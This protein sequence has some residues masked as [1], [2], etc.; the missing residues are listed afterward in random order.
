M[1]ELPDVDVYVDCLR[2]RVVGQQL[3]KVRLATPFVLRSVAPPL[4]ELHGKT[5]TEVRRLGKRIVFALDGD[6][7]L[8]I[9]L[10]I[11]GRFKWKPG[12]PSESTL[13]TRPRGRN[14]LVVFSFA[15]GELSL[16]EAGSKR[17]ASLHAVAG[18]TALRE[19]DRGGAEPLEIDLDGFRAVLHAE[20]HT[21]KRT[22]TDPRLFSG[23]GNAYSDEILHR[24]RLSPLRWTSHLD[25]DNEQGLFEACQAVLSEWR[26]RLRTEVGDGFPT[27]VTAFR[28]EMAVHGKYRQPCPVCD[29]PVQRIVYAENECNYCATCQTDGKLLKDRALSQLLRKDWPRTVQELEELKEQSRL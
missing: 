6:L 5:V 13:S 27:K 25:A 23:I 26:D 2:E 3:L 9:H 28:P 1:P 18:S 22:L 29:S 21:L 20:N 19:F 17:R 14:L 15:N 16:T 11:A 24:A 7:Y 12:A 4:T 8:V 10:M